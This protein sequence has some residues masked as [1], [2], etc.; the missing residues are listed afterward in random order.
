MEVA[1]D[2]GVEEDETV[3]GVRLPN[4]ERS[5]PLLLTVLLLLTAEHQQE[6]GWVERTRVQT[7]GSGRH[8][9]V[10]FWSPR[11]SASQGVLSRDPYR[12]LVDVLVDLPVRFQNNVPEVPSIYLETPIGLSPS[13]FQAFSWKYQRV[14]K[15]L[16]WKGFA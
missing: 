5:S 9:E 13:P 2:P 6:G 3:Y 10:F 1:S 15:G 11:P 12:V 14:S 7:S 8:P 16:C 4:H